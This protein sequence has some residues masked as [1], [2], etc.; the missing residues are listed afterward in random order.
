MFLSVNIVIGLSSCPA[1]HNKTA[2]PARLSLI[3]VSLNLKQNKLT[4]LLHIVNTAAVSPSIIPP[5]QLILLV[6]V[7]HFSGQLILS[8]I[9]SNPCRSI[10]RGDAAAETLPRRLCLGDAASEMLPRRR[11]LVDAA[12]ETDHQLCLCVNVHSECR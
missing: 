3:L 7:A 2:P 6:E 1:K 11:C 9:L 4:N 10:Q 8:D 5:V 12:S